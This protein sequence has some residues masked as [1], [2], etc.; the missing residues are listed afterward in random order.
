MA[1][2]SNRLGSNHVLVVHSLDGLDEIS[3]ASETCVAEL[4]DG[5]VTEYTIDP[6]ALGVKS[7][8]LTG[9][10]VEDAA[11]SLALIRDALGKREG[12]FADKA[13]S[14]IATQCRSSDLCR[15][16]RSN[17]RAGSGDG[18]GCH[19]DRRGA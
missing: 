18:A 2:V 19:S 13:A 6:E 7:G 16:C 4:K 14:M 17:T 12:K 5:Q 1:E 11:G 3:I 15:E 9:L 10:S 8:N